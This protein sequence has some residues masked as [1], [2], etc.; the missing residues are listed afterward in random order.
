[1]AGRKR[2]TP[3]SI[4]KWLK[5]AAKPAT[6]GY[7]QCR[8]MHAT[9]RI[10]LK[11]A[12]ELARDRSARSPLPWAQTVQL[13]HVVY[14][15]MPT[16]LREEGLEDPALPK[17]KLGALL[18]RVCAGEALNLDE[19]AIVTRLARRSDRDAEGSPVGASKLLN[20][21]SPNEYPMYDS[22]VAR[23]FY[24]RG[25]TFPTYSQTARWHQYLAT[26][27]A[28]RKD[29][30]VKAACVSIRRAL[31]RRDLPDT[32]IIELVLFCQSPSKR[33]RQRLKAFRKA[34]RAA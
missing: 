27:R 22:R 17:R 31:R 9:Y 3:I 11:H 23:A 12:Q 30:R 33:D 29:R 10:M 2:V 25:I 34:Q 7:L 8:P 14:A 18:G 1:M 19:L 13:M 15:W 32:R 5:L 24:H 20:L 6:L 26:V 21:L 16:M 28:W 4:E